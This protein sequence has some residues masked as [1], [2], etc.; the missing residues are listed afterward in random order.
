MRKP[1]LFAAGTL[2]LLAG[3]STAH[4]Q[5]CEIKVGAMGPM[6]GG[7]A[8]W[9]LAILGATELAAAEA[10]ADGGLKVGDKKCK[11]TVVPFDSKYTA[12]GAAAGSNALAAEG[13]HVIVGPV[14]SPEA[15]GIK[16]VSARND[17]ITW[18]AAFARNAIEPKFPLAFH[19]NPAP[20]LWADPLIK[21]AMKHFPMK[22]VALV[23]PNDQ[24]GTDIVAV[25]AAA[26]KANGIATREEYYQRGTT[27]FAPIVT[28]ILAGHPDVVDTASSPP[29]DAGVIVKQLRLAGFTGPI[30]RLGGAGTEEILRVSGGVEV[31]KDFYWYETVAIEDPKVKEIDALYKKLLGKDPVG[32]TSMWGDLPAAR[33]TLKAISAAG[34]ADDAGKVAAAM[35]AL[36]VEDP[37][38]GK[39]FWTGKK[40]YG[41]AQELHFPWGAGLIENG[42]LVG[43]TRMEAAP[44]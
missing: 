26:Y 9:G 1:L 16:P 42:K 24:G 34:T 37:N 30:G 11:V 7:A 10:N 32:G 28:R 2:A 43:V 4:A 25:D 36:P 29:G 27:N 23:A 44:E 19:I 41:L 5:S 33:M 13:I 39:G 18:N 14:G 21:F 38:M 8:Q 20:V 17:Q 12:D 35:R 22:T 15:T 31:L 3:L 40:T 6:S